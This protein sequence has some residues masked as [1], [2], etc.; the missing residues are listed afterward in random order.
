MACKGG[1][2]IAIRI[3]IDRLLPP[4]RDRSVAIEMP[5]I[6]AAVLEA[7]M[8]ADEPT[9]IQAADKAE[10]AAKLVKHNLYRL[11]CNRHERGCSAR[12]KYISD[13]LLWGKR[14]CSLLWGKRS[15]SLIFAM[16][17]WARAKRR[18]P[19]ACSG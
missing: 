3:V 7:Q 16:R 18:D 5:K 2:L 15:C 19:G 1:D 6:N 12:T 9:A 14:S 13:S 10:A 17:P 8:R 4:R 11:R